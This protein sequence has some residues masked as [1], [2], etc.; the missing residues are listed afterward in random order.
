L[1]HVNEVGKVAGRLT[2]NPKDPRHGTVGGYT[3][4]GCRCTPCCTAIKE[5]VAKRK[6]K[7]RAAMS[8][9]DHGHWGYR[10]AGCRCDVCKKGNADVNKERWSAYRVRRG[11]G[12]I[13]KAD[14][15]KLA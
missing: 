1:N 7:K 5:S 9:S 3:Y 11:K 4:W 15:G 6:A 12:K 2:Q 8:E 10:N 14:L 13:P